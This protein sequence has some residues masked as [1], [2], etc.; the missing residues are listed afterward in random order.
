MLIQ[1][2]GFCCASL[3][4][5]FLVS[6]DWACC[7][8]CFHWLAIYVIAIHFDGH[9]V[10]VAFAGNNGKTPALVH[11]QQFLCCIKTCKYT[12]QCLAQGGNVRHS[13]STLLPCCLW[14]SLSVG[15]T[16]VTS[17]FHHFVECVPCHCCYVYP[18]WG[19]LD[20]GKNCSQMLMSAWGR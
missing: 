2:H 14:S 15:L 11:L 16:L 3:L 20:S 7:L 13:S 19:W 9:Q 1:C 5:N 8:L 17:K 18:I 10:F 12:S 4:A 6:F